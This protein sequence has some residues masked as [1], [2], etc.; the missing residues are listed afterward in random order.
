MEVTAGGP[1]NSN[2]EERKG[3]A[4]NFHPGSWGREEKMVTF[5]L[6]GNVLEGLA[7]KQEAGKAKGYVCSKT[8]E[9][10]EA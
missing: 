4:R 8:V 10:P 5:L 9:V 1:G 3:R 7:C 2:W 6:T